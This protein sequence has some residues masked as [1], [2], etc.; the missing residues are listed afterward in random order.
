MSVAVSSASRPEISDTQSLEDD[1][2]ASQL[3]SPLQDEDVDPITPTNSSNNL[4]SLA[5]HPGFFSSDTEVDEL[6][7]LHETQS[8]P[9][10]HATSPRAQFYFPGPLPR[11]PAARGETVRVLSQPPPHPEA[12]RRID[13]STAT[14]EENS[15]RNH[16]DQDGGLV[17]GP[18][19][20]QLER[21]KGGSS[22]GGTSVDK[23]PQRDYSRRFY[24]PD[25][26]L[27]NQLAS[28]ARSPERSPPP[29]A[30]NSSFKRS[31]LRLSPKSSVVTAPPAADTMGTPVIV[32]KAPPHP[33]AK[34]LDS[35]ASMSSEVELAAP[36]S[37]SS[38]RATV[39]AKFQVRVAGVAEGE[40]IRVCGND[41]VLGAWDVTK[42]V[43]LKQSAE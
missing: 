17:D 31:N 32:S 27:N 41:T 37:T 4:Q 8:T 18:E 5:R 36:G 3:S 22:S 28:R 12:V 25:V 23:K 39:E 35:N 26:P 19:T 33:F 6:H 38:S 7:D 10:H 13:R 42:S 21:A 14:T 1:R 24:V 15:R 20:P 43:P 9:D 34:R 30:K 40:E 2:F 11:E 16:K 29:I